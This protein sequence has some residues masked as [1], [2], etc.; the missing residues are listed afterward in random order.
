[1]TDWRRFMQTLLVADEIGLSL[2]VSRM[3]FDDE[4]LQS[5]ADE[6]GRAYDEMDALEAGAIANPSEDRRVGHYW[7]RAPELAP[8]PSISEAITRARKQAIDFAQEIHT[9]KHFRN[10]LVIGIGGSSLGPQLISDA[11]GDPDLD[12]LNV[13]FLDNTDPQGMDR[14]LRQLGDDLKRTLT[15]VASKSGA[16]QE[17]FNSMT[18]VLAAYTSAGLN[19]A[20]RA[21]AITGQGSEL[22][23]LAKTEQWLARFPMWDWVGG[24]TSVTSAVGLV[25]ATLQGVAVD[26]LLAGAA[27]CDR[28]TR[29]RQTRQNPAA[30]LALMWFA[31]T[32]GDAERD[33]VVLPYK[34]SL[35]LMSRYLQQL[36]MESLGKRHNLAGEVVHQGLTVY[37]NKGST[38]Q[39]AYV[40]Q[41]RDGPDDF[42]VTFVEVLEDGGGDDVEIRP[43]IM[44]G[45]F[46]RGFLYGTRH[47]LSEAGRQSMTITIRRV[48]SFHV[49]VLIALYERAVG[50]YASLIRVNA[51]DQPGVEAGKLAASDFIELQ[52]RL[53]R[54]LESRD[55]P[56]TAQTLVDSLG[57][58]ESIE[59]AFVLLRGLAANG[60]CAATRGKTPFETRFR[61]S[62]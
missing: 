8:E 23:R 47:A 39:H 58:P 55:R 3:H 35:K 59:A 57:E 18:V 36:V 51:Y 9:A 20:K 12:R 31:A 50:F 6:M 56:E 61:R 27:A 33:M 46:L 25:P 5:M 60:R 43:G 29:T 14:L 34:D 49:G 62:S 11:L 21:V 19:F 16:T 2:D 4:W 40:Q 32:K 26:R 28:V 54:E 10:L 22:D 24:R 1:M 30:L 7:L 15:V 17:T 41:L 53:L 52:E 45:D 13:Y 37:G 44:S 48:D 42:F 38:D